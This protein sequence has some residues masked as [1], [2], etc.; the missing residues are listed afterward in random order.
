MKYKSDYLIEEVEKAVKW[1]NKQFPMAEEYAK[2]C[3]IPYW[4]YV[5][6][7]RKFGEVLTTWGEG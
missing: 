2:E 3:P 5:E 6:V 7:Y 1:F 4:V